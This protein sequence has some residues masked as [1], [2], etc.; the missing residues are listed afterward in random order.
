MIHW[1]GY[2]YCQKRVKSNGTDYGTIKQKVRKGQNSMHA[3]K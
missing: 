2:K 3:E 1:Y